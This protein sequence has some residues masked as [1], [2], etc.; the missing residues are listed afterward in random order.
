MAAS[1][2]A[3]LSFKVHNKGRSQ[4]TVQI[5]RRALGRLEAFLLEMERPWRDA[6]HED[7]VI[8]TGLWLHRRGLKDPLSRRTHIAAVREFYK[9][10]WQRGLV[11][12]W[13]AEHVPY[14]EV[15]RR[16]PAVM[17]LASA[18]KLMWAPDFETFE[19]VRDAAILGVLIGC[20]PRVS[21]V[22]GLNES[23]VVRTV[24]DGHPRMVLKVSEKGK[25][26]RLLPVPEQAALLLGIYLEHPAL[27]EIDRALPDG[28][29]VLFVNLKNRTIPEHEYRGEH[30][31]L[32]RR[33][34]WEMVRRYGRRAGLPEEQ[35]HP[36]AMR[37]LF[38]TE[39]VEEDTNMLT[40]QMLLGHADPKTSEIYTHTAMRKLSRVI[41]KANP[42]AKMKTPAS[43]LLSK[44]KAMG[45]A[46]SGRL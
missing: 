31:R 34:I 19:G 17:S 25:K 28:D 27:A 32:R 41:D 12:S 26:E 4:H 43:E 15:G 14:P 42:L 24:V 36:H 33:A 35:I 13:A 37:H 21:G 18:E 16:I 1:V 45:A 8:F 6:C 46:R 11:G 22:V 5:Y 20:G 44:L 39:L 38:G 23:H 2:E 3:F 9:W 40:V 7:L 30:R 29:K 10:A